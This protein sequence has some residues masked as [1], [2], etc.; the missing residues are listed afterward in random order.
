MG[1]GS[2]KA[3]GA[4]SKKEL[5]D[6]QRISG[7]MGSAKYQAML[8]DHLIPFVPL[9]GVNPPSCDDLRRYKGYQYSLH[10]F[11][12]KEWRG[13]RFVRIPFF[14]YGELGLMLPQGCVPSAS[15][16]WKKDMGLIVD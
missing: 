11:L 7:S 8:Y 3:W 14:M 9:L 6:I 16:K 1:G 13:Y 10:V 2:A 4:F 12:S 15:L 5:C